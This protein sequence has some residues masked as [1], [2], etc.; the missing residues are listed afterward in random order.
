MLQRR[1]R[2]R[3]L[4]IL[5]LKARRKRRVWSWVRKQFWF[6]SLVAGD[7]ADEWWNENLRFRRQT[8]YRIV[9][10]VSPRMTKNNTCLRQ[11]IPVQKRVA[12]ALWKLATGDTYRSTG[13]QFGIARNTAFYITR[14]FCSVMVTFSARFIKCPTNEEILMKHLCR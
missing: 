4:V 14:E 9:D 8:F 7:L 13:L 2:R 6:E 10:L 11:A 12:V 3:R 5:A 1:S